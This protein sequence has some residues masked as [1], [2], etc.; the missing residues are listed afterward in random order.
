MVSQ[1]ISNVP[2]SV[3]ISKFSHNWF[4]ITYGVNAGGNG[5]IIA[6]LANLIALR[7][8]KDRKFWIYFHR[9][10]IPYLI[11]TATILYVLL[12]ALNSNV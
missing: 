5:F 8:V 11:I 6:S 2:T 3:L 10:S 1:I 4:A 9:Y 12:N 7:I